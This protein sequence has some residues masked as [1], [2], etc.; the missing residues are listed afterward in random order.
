MGE[1]GSITIPQPLEIS[2]KYTKDNYILDVAKTLYANMNFNNEKYSKNEAT[3]YAQYAGKRA[4]I[5]AD[6][7]NNYFK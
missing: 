4:K 6:V 7:L 5:L 2:S 3:T 1:E